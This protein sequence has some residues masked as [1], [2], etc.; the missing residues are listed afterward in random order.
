MFFFKTAFL[1]LLATFAITYS[2]LVHAHDDH[3]HYGL[4]ARDAFP[5]ITPNPEFLARDL[6]E[7]DF[8]EELFQ[9]GFEDFLASREADLEETA[10]AEREIVGWL[11]KRNTFAKRNIVKRDVQVRVPRSDQSNLGGP[12]DPPPLHNKG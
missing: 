1:F 11:L 3:D 9:R 6:D 5:D 7:R 2:T 10:L 12:Q 8:D 4:D